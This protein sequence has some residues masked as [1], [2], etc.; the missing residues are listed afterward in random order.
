MGNPDDI[1]KGLYLCCECCDG[2]D[3]ING[4]CVE[5]P[6]THEI[7]CIDALLRDAREYIDN[8][9]ADVER[10]RGEIER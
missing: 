10:G 3:E 7:N 6:Y 1:K 9:E 2:I 4:K 5:C 8:L